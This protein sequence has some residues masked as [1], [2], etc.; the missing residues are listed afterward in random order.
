MLMLDRFSPFIT[1]NFKALNVKFSTRHL[2]GP[3]FFFLEDNEIVCI[4]LVRDIAFYVDH[5]FSYYENIGIGKFVIMDNGSTDDTIDR[6]SRHRGA[7]V[8]QCTLPFRQYQPYLR[9]HA[10]TGYARGGWRLAIDADELFCYPGDE[11]LPL[12]ALTRAL[13]ERGYDGVVAQML[14]LVP[15]AVDDLRLTESYAAA[16]SACGYYN[17]DDIIYY[18][19][20]STEIPFHAFMNKNK[21]KHSEIKFMFGGIRRRLF[22]EHCCLTKHPLFRMAPT[23]RP[24]PH[25]HVSTGLVCAD[26]TA[27]IRHY[28]FTGDFIE[29]ERDRERRALLSHREG[30]QRLAVYDS[31]TA[32]SFDLPTNRKFETADR[33][34]DDGFLVASND[35]RAMLGL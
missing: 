19:Y 1:R 20:F 11:R 12:D 21:M 2:S 25:P 15:S 22:G 7:I 18:D 30:R 9:Y 23:V 31:A 16:T 10:V 26:F 33:L 24:L 34:L 17:L 4:L 8:V 28:K 27:L 32:L 35:A 5:M 14:D 3:K 13:A 29:R 6:V